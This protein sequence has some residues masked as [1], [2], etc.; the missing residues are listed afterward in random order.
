MLIEI[1]DGLRIVRGFGREEG[2]YISSL[3]RKTVDI[4]RNK[5]GF[6]RLVF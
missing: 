6:V 4:E 1:Y 2:S 3:G 5:M